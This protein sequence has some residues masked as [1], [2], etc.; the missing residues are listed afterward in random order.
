MYWFTF[1]WIFFRARQ[2]RPW[3]WLLQCVCHLS[4]GQSRPTDHFPAMWTGI[5]AMAEEE[6]SRGLRLQLRATSLHRSQENAL[7]LAYVSLNS[8]RRKWPHWLRWASTI[9]NTNHLNE[10]LVK[11]PNTTKHPGI[12]GGCPLGTF[13]T[14]GSCQPMLTSS[15]RFFRV[16]YSDCIVFVFS[17]IQFYGRSLSWWL[18]SS[19]KMQSLS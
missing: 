6:L 1:W 5:D 14:N 9:T 16:T 19:R 7:A 8:V 2:R 11:P 17:L 13:C 3:E 12:C 10:I 15:E 18:C 4:A